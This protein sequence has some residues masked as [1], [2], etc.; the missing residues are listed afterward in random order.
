M[1][2]AVLDLEKV[3]RLGMKLVMRLVMV[4]GMVLVMVLDNQWERKLD[5]W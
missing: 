1:L 3:K 5:R 4:L 2:D